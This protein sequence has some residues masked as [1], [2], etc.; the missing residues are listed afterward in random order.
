MALADHDAK[1]TIPALHDDIGI[2]HHIK[3]TNTN[4]IR[5][6][7]IVVN[8]AKIEIIFRSFSKEKPSDCCKI[9]L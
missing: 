6:S 7:R 9:L 1:H 3:I 4:E 2:Q 8:L 5:I